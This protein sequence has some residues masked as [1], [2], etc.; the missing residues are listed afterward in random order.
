MEQ[1]RQNYE[2]QLTL[3]KEEERFK[4]EELEKELEQKWKTV[5]R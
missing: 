4:L 1:Q 5:V 3:A 2:T